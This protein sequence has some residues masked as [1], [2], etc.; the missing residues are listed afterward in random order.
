MTGRTWAMLA[1]EDCPGGSATWPGR[2]GRRMVQGH[3][4]SMELQTWR[5]PEPM[6]GTPIER[7]KTFEIAP[8]NQYRIAIET[9][10]RDLRYVSVGQHGQLALSS[11]PADLLPT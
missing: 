3:L 8:L 6:L 5:R 10:E 7:G 4:P 11:M 1:A 2:D 9:D